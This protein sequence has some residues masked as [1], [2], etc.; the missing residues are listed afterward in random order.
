M[1]GAEG[2]RGGQD[3]LLFDDAGLWMVLWQ[4]CQALVQRISQQV[5][6][7]GGLAQTRLC[8]QSIETDDIY[9]LNSQT[10]IKKNKTSYATSQCTNITGAHLNLI[11]FFMT[12]CF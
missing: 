12:C 8:L 6:T 5:Q 11:T 1:A 9:L 2:R 7:L 3:Q 10:D 4:L